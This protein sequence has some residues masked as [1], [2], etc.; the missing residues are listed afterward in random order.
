MKLTQ[1]TSTWPTQTPN[2]RGPNAKYIPLARVG[3]T[4]L[5]VGSP[6]LGVG[7]LDTDMLVST[8]RN[9]RVGGLDQREAP[10][11]RDRVAVE[12]RLKAYIPL[13]HNIPGVGGWRWAIPLTPTPDAS[14]WN[15]GRVGSQHK[16]LALAMY[17]SCFLCR[18]HLRLVPNANPIASGIWA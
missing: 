9:S 17:I 12:Y 18:F 7:F 14:Q 3:C 6:K 10:K 15:I 11:Q 1:T 4:R 16:I 8:T 13:R 2:A 5:H